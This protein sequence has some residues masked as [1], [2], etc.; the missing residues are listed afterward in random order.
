MRASFLPMRKTVS[1]KGKV[2]SIVA[3]TRSR[4]HLQV[5]FWGRGPS[6][7]IVIL[8]E[9]RRELIDVTSAEIGLPQY[10][11]IVPMVQQLR[12]NTKTA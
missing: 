6:G 11:S 12:P 8:E 7:E 9:S 4:P 1:V 2:I 10:V 5:R 3:Q